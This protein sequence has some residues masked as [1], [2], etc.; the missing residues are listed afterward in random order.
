MRNHGQWVRDRDSEIEG[1]GD[2][3]VRGLQVKRA[4]CT[5]SETG[6]PECKAIMVKMY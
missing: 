1:E 6:R 5:S 4:G 2:Y 3:R